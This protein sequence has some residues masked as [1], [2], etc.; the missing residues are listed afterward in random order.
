MH[1]LS[2]FL[3]KI[4]SEGFPTG[5]IENSETSEIFFRLFHFRHFDFDLIPKIENSEEENWEKNC[6][7]P[8][9]KYMF[10][11]SRIKSN[12]Y[13]SKFPNKRPLPPRLFFLTKKS[14]PSGGHLQLY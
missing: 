2:L 14:D 7:Y 9:C 12:V 11:A 13:Y 5:Q 6:D 8:T 1:W 3:M 4:V 10:K